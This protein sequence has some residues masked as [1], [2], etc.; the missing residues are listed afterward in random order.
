[1]QRKYGFFDSSDKSSTALHD[2]L[3][4]SSS[5]KRKRDVD[6]SEYNYVDQV[7]IKWESIYRYVEKMERLF[8]LNVHVSKG[9]LAASYFRNIQEY[10]FVPFSYTNDTGALFEMDEI[11]EGVIPIVAKD[12]QPGTGVAS[13]L[14]DESVRI[15]RIF[16]DPACINKQLLTDIYKLCKENN[17]ITLVH[18]KFDTFLNDKMDDIKLTCPDRKRPRC[19]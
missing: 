9:E 6:K 1:M 8:D 12:Y 4:R 17:N 10:K 13:I 15:T 18:I 19:R 16:F 2:T 7:T 11:D 14:N 5:H 3:H